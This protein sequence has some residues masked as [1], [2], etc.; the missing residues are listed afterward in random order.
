[1]FYFFWFFLFVG[2]GVCGNFILDIVYFVLLFC[3]FVFL[4]VVCCEIFY[5]N[6]YVQLRQIFYDMI[7]RNGLCGGYDF[8]CKNQ[9]IEEKELC[10]D[11]VEGEGEGEGDRDFVEEGGRDLVEEGSRDLVEVG[12]VECDLGLLFM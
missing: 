2:F 1:M 10:D 9:V 4:E 12:E 3:F 11:F 5:L 8:Q 7:I 6:L